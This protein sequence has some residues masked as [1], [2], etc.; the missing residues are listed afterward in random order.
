MRAVPL[1][2]YRRP[3]TPSAGTIGP[4][5]DMK[6]PIGQQVNAMSGKAF[7]TL[8]AGL[9][10]DNPPAADDKPMVDK[11][12]QIGIVPGKRFDFDQL[13]APTQAA[14][15]AASKAAIAQMKAHLP[16]AGKPMNGWSVITDLGSYGTNPRFC[17]RWSL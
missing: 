15:N 11:L 8:F 12:A 3:Y 13:P 1:S 2:S 6:T 14:L 10:K 7:F 16:K 9:L 4:S 17:A 5:I